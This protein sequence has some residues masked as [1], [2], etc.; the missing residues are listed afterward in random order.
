[1]DALKHF[2][3]NKQNDTDDKQG[4]DLDGISSTTIDVPSLTDLIADLSSIGKEDN[5]SNDSSEESLANTSNKNDEDDAD[6]AEAENE[7]REDKEGSMSSSEKVQN[8]D[9][10][11]STPL[12]E[13]DVNSNSVNNSSTSPQNIAAKSEFDDLFASLA[14]FDDDGGEGGDSLSLQSK[15]TQHKQDGEVGENEKESQSDVSES[16][17]KDDTP[18][19]VS[20][21]AKYKRKAQTAVGRFKF[22]G[23]DS[24]NEDSAKNKD[25]HG[26]LYFS[27]Y[28]S[29]VGPKRVRGNKRSQSTGNTPSNSGDGDN[30]SMFRSITDAFKVLL[31]IL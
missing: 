10:T 22:G 27:C 9:I 30:F 26:I 8:H 17:G 31:T 3:D 24:T 28:S 20:R 15:A 25:E 6:E 21:I 18:K 23:N 5:E 4:D 19:L 1:M 13:Q 11:P 29:F 16:F 2:D 14:G 12:T 7:E